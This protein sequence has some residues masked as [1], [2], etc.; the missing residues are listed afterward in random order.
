MTSEQKKPG[1]ALDA[2]RV[3][4]NALEFGT[5]PR[6]VPIDRAWI[7]EILA[8]TDAQVS[9]GG[10]ASLELTLQADRT[11]LVRG[12][13]GVDFRVPCAR[14]LAPALVD[15]SAENEELCVTYV[16]ADRLRSW[17]EFTGAP[18]DEDEIEPLAPAELDEIGYVGTT[19]D[20]RSLVSEQILL[21]YPMRALCSQGEACQ[22]L[23][24][25]CGAELNPV[26]SSSE[27]AT[28][29]ASASTPPARPEAC[30]SCGLRLLEEGGAVDE[31]TD[32]PWK[33]ALAKVKL[34]EGD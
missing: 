21:A 8:D 13:L 16:P 23:C 27:S 28:R 18:E 10:L 2:L 20:L 33:R 24:M 3:D 26:V 17:A 9:E 29:S 11:V 12:K 7:A 1:D 30:P 34:D 19:I 22:G 31:P 5:H 15:V 14:C 32:S 6:E 25:R 4:L